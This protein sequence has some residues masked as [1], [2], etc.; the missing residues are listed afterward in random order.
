MLVLFIKVLNL[1]LGKSFEIQLL[2]IFMNFKRNLIDFDINNLSSFIKV[3]NLFSIRGKLRN[4][5]LGNI[6]LISFKK[7][8]N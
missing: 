4:S 1:I 6:I 5:I 3:S 2:A 7:E 8:F